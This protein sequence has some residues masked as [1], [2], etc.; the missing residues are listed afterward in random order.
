MRSLV[1]LESITDSEE[2]LWE[3]DRWVRLPFGIGWAMWGSDPDYRN[4]IPV[5]RCSD[6]IPTDMHR[7]MKVTPVTTHDPYLGAIVGS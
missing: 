2:F 6:R 1:M 5:C 4:A 7:T 3:G